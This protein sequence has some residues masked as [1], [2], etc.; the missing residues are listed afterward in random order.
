[1]P[2]LAVVPTTGN[3]RTPWET[4]P[5]QGRRK[6]SRTEGPRRANTDLMPLPGRVR[7]MIWNPVVGT[8]G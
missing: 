8:T 6:S 4:P 3:G 1:M 7:G 2:I 5:R